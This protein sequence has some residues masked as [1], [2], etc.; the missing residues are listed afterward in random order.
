MEVEGTLGTRGWRESVVVRKK[1]VGVVER[2]DET[3]WWV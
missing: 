2:M 3:V 1:P